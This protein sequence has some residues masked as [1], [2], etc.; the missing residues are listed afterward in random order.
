MNDI[1]LYGQ[2]YFLR[3]YAHDARREQMYQQEYRRLDARLPAGGRVL[4][5]GCGTGG[6]LANFGDRWATYGYEPSKYA[7]GVSASRG[8]EMLATLPG[9]P[10]ESMDLV[11]FRGTLQHISEPM[12]ALGHATR[13][14]RPGGTLAILATP[15]TDSLVYKIWGDLPA[16]EAERNWVLFGERCLVNILRRLGYTDVEA[17]HPYLGTPYARPVSDVCQFLVSLL[18]GY[19]KFPFW[20]NMMEIYA[21]KK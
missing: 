12:D 14:L 1:Q 11:V 3:H 5:I 9:V 8:I 4:D 15:D 6:F 2:G 20:G 10:D 19:R 18:F 7:H 21:R 17:L 16:L 13:I